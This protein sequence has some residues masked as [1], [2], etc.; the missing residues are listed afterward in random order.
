MLFEKEQHAGG[1]LST[2]NVQI[3]SCIK[4]KA[5]TEKQLARKI[6]I[7]MLVLSPLVTELMLMGYVGTFRRRRLYFFSREYFSITPEGIE[8]LEKARSPLQN[9]IELIRERALETVE[10]IAAASPALKILLMF[11]KAFYKTAKV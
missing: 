5:R 3:L 4:A 8:A 7:G 9:I 10:N 6:G 2:L 11:G 1:K